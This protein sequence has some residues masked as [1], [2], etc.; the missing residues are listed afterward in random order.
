MQ[1]ILNGKKFYVIRSHL[2]NIDYGYSLCDLRQNTNTILDNWFFFF[3]L[4]ENYIISYYT[5]YSTPDC[6]R[7]QLWDLL[8]STEW[9]FLLVYFGIVISL[10]SMQST[11][12]GLCG[13]I[14]SHQYYVWVQFVCSSLPLINIWY[15]RCISLIISLPK[16]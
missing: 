7:W 6:T 5:N 10:R 12:T 9:N 3:F 14:S 15:K 11:S 16:T 2:F 4:T 8:I 1:S 13:H